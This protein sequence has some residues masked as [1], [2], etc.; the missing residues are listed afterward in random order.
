MLRNTNNLQGMPSCLGISAHLDVVVVMVLFPRRT[1][2]WHDATVSVVM[3]LLAQ[4]WFT[5]YPARRSL[6]VAF[7]IITCS[8]SGV[9]A[10]V[11]EQVAAPESLVS[12]A[13]RD[14]RGLHPRL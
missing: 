1:M 7:I 12:F 9:V 11:W 5:N 10:T 4:W 2:V 14:V 6:A 8:P 13:G 3:A